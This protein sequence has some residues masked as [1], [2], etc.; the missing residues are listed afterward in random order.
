MPAQLSFP[1]GEHLV[2]RFEHGDPGVSGGASRLDL[3]K[4]LGDKL[5]RDPDVIRIAEAT[6]E[7]FQPTDKPF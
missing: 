4:E 7:P 2:V 6:L 3:G 5:M 1:A